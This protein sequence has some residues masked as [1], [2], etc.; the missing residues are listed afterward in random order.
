L[1]E[2]YSNLIAECY[3]YVER[4][5]VHGGK[6]SERAVVAALAKGCVE[7]VNTLQLLCRINR[8]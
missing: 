3:G 8:L 4:D 6:A 1:K 5:A 2:I 7:G